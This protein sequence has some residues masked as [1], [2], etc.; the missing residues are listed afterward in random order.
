M[1]YGWSHTRLNSLTVNAGLSSLDEVTW[2]ELV[3]LL[4]NAGL[5]G[6][7][8]AEQCIGSI[9]SELYGRLNSLMINAGS[10]GE[11]GAGQRIGDI[12]AAPYGDSIL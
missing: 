1:V 11:T 7:T 9:L 5:N 3:F 6:E 4:M 10:G 2:I 12:W 8:G